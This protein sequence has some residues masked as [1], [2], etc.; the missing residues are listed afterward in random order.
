MHVKN[1]HWSISTYT[2]ISIMCICGYCMS[3]GHPS[4]GKATVGTIQCV[5][6]RLLIQPSLAINHLHSAGCLH[7]RRPPDFPPLARCSLWHL[8]IH[9]N[10]QTHMLRSENAY[11]APRV[12]SMSKMEVEKMLTYPD[13][14]V[15][16]RMH[17]C[18]IKL[19]SLFYP[20]QFWWEFEN[21][22]GSPSSVLSAMQKGNI[23][24]S[25]SY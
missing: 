1:T 4:C 22:K 25:T 16:R 2:L 10:T 18:F 13:R 8:N 12:K 11:L 7:E 9:P 14:F 24:W 17:C 6:P 19:N 3:V 21:V 20:V 23:F 5:W 15:T